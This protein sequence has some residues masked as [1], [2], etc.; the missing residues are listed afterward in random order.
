MVKLS[1]F[2][3]A[4]GDIVVADRGYRGMAGLAHVRAVGADVL[5][6]VGWRSYGWRDQSGATVSLTARFDRVGP[7]QIDEAAL[8]VTGPDGTTQPVRV[9]AFGQSSAAVMLEELAGVMPDTARW[10]QASPRIPVARP[11]PP[12]RRPQGMDAGRIRTIHPSLAA[13]KPIRRRQQ[14]TTT[15]KATP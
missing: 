11:A 14:K 4:P 7:G 6:W 10:G 13:P 12:D 9:I 5:L 15:T 1:R 3:F 8:L 2:D